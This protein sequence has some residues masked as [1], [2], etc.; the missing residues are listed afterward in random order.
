[1]ALRYSFQSFGLFVA[2]WVA[3]YK[4]FSEKQAQE[5]AQKEHDELI[6][7]TSC[8]AH[9]D[10]ELIIHIDGFSGYS[11]YRDPSFRNFL[12]SKKIK[13]TLVDDGA[14]YGVR[15]NAL[16]SGEAHLAVYTVDALTTSSAEIGDLPGT[17]INISDVSLGA[18]AAV[19]NKKTFPNVDALNDPEV[20]FVCVPDSPSETLARVI[21]QQFNLPLLDKNPFLFVDSP[22]EVYKMYRTSKPTDKH[23]FITWEPYVSRMTDNPDYHVLMDSSKVRNAIVDVLVAQR[24]FVL[25]NPELAEAAVKAYFT[26]IFK[27]RADMAGM[28]MA[29]RSKDWGASS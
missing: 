3:W 16:K 6:E 17:I 5:Q 19:A 10:H 11:P 21:I 23:I 25:K 29:G 13:L 20:K 9:F 14:D 12:S 26:T 4:P 15:V 28:I 8:M 18:D 2:V 24:S 27:R 7:A 1:M 22:D